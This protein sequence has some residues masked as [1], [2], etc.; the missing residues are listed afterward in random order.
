MLFLAMCGS[1]NAFAL[2]FASGFVRHPWIGDGM[3]LLS[4]LFGNQ[5]GLL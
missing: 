3:T 4:M 1:C 2:R 5:S